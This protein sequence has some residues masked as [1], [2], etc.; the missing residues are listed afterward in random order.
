MSVNLPETPPENI[1]FTWN[2]KQYIKADGILTE[3]INHKGNVYRVRHIGSDSITYLLND[4][5]NNW[6]HGLTLA[7][8]KNDL[9]YK[10]HNRDTTLYKTFTL[11]SELAIEAATECYRAIT[12]ACVLGIKMFLETT[13][14]TKEMITI[15][16]LIEITQN[17]FGHIQFKEFFSV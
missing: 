8:A 12:G 11:D 15:R 7:D 14:I 1:I 2:N 4:G 5:D 16:E 3:V 17:Q 10:I 6:A 13:N 9:L